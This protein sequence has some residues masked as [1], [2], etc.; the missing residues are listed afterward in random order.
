MTKTGVVENDCMFITPSE[1][2][3]SIWIV[4]K[5]EPNSYQLEMYKVTPEHTIG[6]LEISLTS[7]GNNATKAKVS[8][9]FTAI[10][11]AGE[12]FL[13]EFTHKWYVDFMTGWEKAM[14]HYLSTGKKLA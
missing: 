13:Q 4:T 6:K 11:S 8:Y 2:Q 12:Q 10:G 7:A 5:H 14:N 9:E 3:N 1:S